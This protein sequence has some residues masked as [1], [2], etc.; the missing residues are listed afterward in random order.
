M[1]RVTLFS[2]A[3][4]LMF[5][6][7]FSQ[8]APDSAATMKAWQ[9]YMT[10]GDVHK[11]IAKDDGQW[12]EEITTWMAPGAPPTKSSA[13]AENKMVLGGRFQQSTHHGSFMDMPFEGMS[14]LGYDNVKKI[15]QITWADNMGTGLMYM[16][17]PWDDATK[18]IH[19]KGKTTDPVTGKDINVRETVKFIDENTQKVE[20]FSTQN[21]KEFKMME[22]NLKRK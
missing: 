12:V 6:T 20:M 1:K 16:E 5:T 4:S 14:T 2:C 18:T 19:L 3:V 15:F 13:I 8:S 22:I 17:G 7:T 9:S 11:M 10:P 21:G